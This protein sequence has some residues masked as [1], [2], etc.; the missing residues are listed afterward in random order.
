MIDRGALVLARTAHETYRGPHRTP[1]D[2]LEFTGR[3]GKDLARR[4]AV[5][6]VEGEGVLEDLD[7]AVS[8]LHEARALNVGPIEA[9]VFEVPQT[10]MGRGVLPV[11]EPPPADDLTFLG[12][13]VIEPMEPYFSP[14]AAGSAGHKVN[15]HGLLATRAEAESLA[16]KM[17]AG[18]DDETPYVA[19]R[20]WSVRA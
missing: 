3:K 1:L 8:L 17:T 2:G 13:D 7:E 14:L 6:V 19:C 15:D 9:I 12:W 11:H 20:V 5:A 10:P 16:A 18:S 4:Y